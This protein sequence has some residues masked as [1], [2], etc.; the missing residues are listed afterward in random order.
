MKLK[1]TGQFENGQPYY[2]VIPKE[3]LTDIEAQ[4]LI[5]SEDWKSNGSTSDGSVLDVSTLQAELF[6]DF[7]YI[8][9]RRSALFIALNEIG[10]Y[11][12]L[13]A[14][15]NTMSTQSTQGMKVKFWLDGMVTLKRSNSYIPAIQQGLQMSDLELNTLW[16][17]AIEIQKETL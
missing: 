16:K 3:S 13:I 7:E 6:D 5:D 14:L 12:D 11:D 15:V 8:D 4:T 9:I 2:A 10:K 1:I 17:N